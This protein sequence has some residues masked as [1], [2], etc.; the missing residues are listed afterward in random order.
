MKWEL[1]IARKRILSWRNRSD[2]KTGICSLS[3]GRKRSEGMDG[4]NVLD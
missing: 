2:R 3:Y 1:P 4:E